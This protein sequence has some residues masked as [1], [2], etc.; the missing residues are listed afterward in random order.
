[1]KKNLLITVV[2]CSLAT[3]AR[4]QKFDS[5]MDRITQFPNKLF[6]KI[7]NKA[8]GLDAALT[9]QTEKYLERMA[10]KEKKLERKL[11]R[12]D[13]LT[14]KTLFAGTQQK[15][16]YFEQQIKKANGGAT[17]ISG[18]YLPYIDSVKGSLSFLQKN[19]QLLNATPEIQNKLA[20]SLNSYNQLQSRLA[21]SQQIK[22][23]IQQRRQQLRNVFSNYVN[24]FG[25][26]KYLDDYNK[27]V[28]YYTQQVREYKEM[29][30][31]PDK[32]EKKALGLLN[33]LPAFQDFM[34]K[35]SMLSSLFNIP[36]NGNPTQAMQ[37]L[38]SRD[39]VMALMQNQVGVSGPNPT[40]MVQQNISSAEGQID[41]L[42][43]KLKVFGGGGDNMD[44]PNFKPNN[45][46][47]KSFL[48][49]LELGS[50]L[51]TQHSNYY[52]PTTTDLGLS[53]GYKVNDRSTIGIGISYKIGWG[54]GFDHVSVTSEGVGLRSFADV[55][56]KGDFYLSGGFEENYQH[57]I[58][59][60]QQIRQFAAWQQSGLIGLSKMVSLKTRL[61]KKTKVQLLWDF[62]SYQQIPR[63]QPFK[64]RVGY[65]F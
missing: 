26:Q 20:G 54:S 62:L 41:Q 16:L 43:D 13:S 60:F 53:L 15:Y 30:N 19:Q 14:A 65:N 59:S 56:I 4:A 39:Q 22:D 64:F 42:R 17:T 24:S 25:A 46:K 32:L 27:Q 9:K 55:K 5:T 63:T 1:M 23:F 48:K 6:A 35:N 11:S 52:F 50:N 33:Q 2:F 3:L 29:L 28:Y 34:K 44:I 57:P 7:Q 8:A 21:V 61:V 45:Q 10:R 40:A 31:D 12:K 36:A 18:E 49:R 38:P 58:R 51:Q 37:G 47:T